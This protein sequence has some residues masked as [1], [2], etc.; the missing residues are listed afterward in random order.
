LWPSPC[1][2]TPAPAT[3]AAAAAT[4]AASWRH[5]RCV[6]PEDPCCRMR[7]ATAV[8]ARHATRCRPTAAS[9]PLCKRCML[10][11]VGAMRGPK[12]GIAQSTAA[13]SAAQGPPRQLLAPLCTAPITQMTCGVRSDDTVPTCQQRSSAAAVM[14]ERR[15]RQSTRHVG[16]NVACAW[17]QK[18]ADGRDVCTH[19]K[20]R[21]ATVTIHPLDNDSALRELSVSV[22]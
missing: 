20:E 6:L 12:L 9:A 18:R 21:T 11:G 10:T 7:C 17:L 5:S 14:R 15:P 1:V 4:A 8:P 16:R 2:A 22:S 3:P 19:N 13:A